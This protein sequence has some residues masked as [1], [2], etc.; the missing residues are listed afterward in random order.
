MS[1]NRFRG[2]QSS[3]HAANSEI[4]QRS[5]QAIGMSPGKSSNNHYGGR[6]DNQAHHESQLF[7]L[8]NEGTS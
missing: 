2:N 1:N 5:M 8:D 7:N 6:G 4:N 3:G